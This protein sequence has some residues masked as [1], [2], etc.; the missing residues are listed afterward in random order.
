MEQDTLNIHHE[1]IEQCKDGDRTAQLKIYNLY[2]RAMYNTSLRI[3]NNTIE[4]EDAMQE[5]F[6]DAFLNIGNYKGEASFGAWLKR[7]VINKSVSI[8]RKRRIF[9][10]FDESVELIPDL[11]NE[12]YSETKYYK[13]DQIKSAF[14]QLDENSRIL[15]SLHLIEGY[16]HKEIAESLGIAHNAIRT[17]YVRAKQ[18]LLQIINQKFVKSTIA[19]NK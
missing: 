1:L 16:N 2:Y 8:I 9:E 7:I 18:K 5:S 11:D 12:N 17:R 15:L 14:D 6:L 10:S 13:I 4:A 19:L 3:L